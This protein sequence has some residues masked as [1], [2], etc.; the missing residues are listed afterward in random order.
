MEMIP[1]LIVSAIVIII[2]FKMIRIVPEQEA[3]VIEEFGKFKKELGAGLHFVVPVIQR[4][5]YKLELR[6]EVIDVMPQV[7]ITNDNVQITVDGILYLK[8][9]DPQKASYG[10]ENYRFATAQLAQTTMRSEIGKI[11]LDR[12]FS[13]RDS[14]N[15]AIVKSVDQASDPWGIKVTRYEIKNLD[16]PETVERAM[17]Q[18]MTA[19]RDKRAEVLE[20]DGVKQAAINDSK[21]NREEAINRSKGEKQKR[22]NEAEGKA[23]A[24]ELQAEATAE[25]IRL[26]A[27]AINKPNGD[28]AKSM[29]IFQQYLA[30]LGNIL[31]N[32]KTSVIPL[33]AA[34][35][36]SL[37]QTILPVLTDKGAK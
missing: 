22:I 5:A 31:K 19:E 36:K 16:P 1:T 21:G 4:I 25:G 23:K 35:V 24:I 17:E 27:Q 10:I 11:E 12:T 7:C 13:E 32:S 2:L 3:W 37:I 20:S 9:I 33:E 29:R 14:I 18:Q 30:Q 8:V 34:Q 6:E 26:I 28:K 15:N